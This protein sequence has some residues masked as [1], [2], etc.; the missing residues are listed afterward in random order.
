MD[1]ARRALRGF[2]VRRRT[3]LCLRLLARVAVLSVS[4]DRAPPF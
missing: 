3:A 2:V 4:V 1:Q